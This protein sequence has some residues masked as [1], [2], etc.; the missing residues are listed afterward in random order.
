MIRYRDRLRLFW[1]RLWIRRDEFH[2]SLNLD[3]EIMVRMTEDEKYSYQL[4]LECRRQ[5]AHENDMRRMETE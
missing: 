4:D 3:V 2:H 5:M 1:H